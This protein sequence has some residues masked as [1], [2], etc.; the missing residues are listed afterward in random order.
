MLGGCALG[1]RHVKN[2]AIRLWSYFIGMR[3]YGTHHQVNGAVNKHG[4]FW[5]ICSQNE[6]NGMVVLNCGISSLRLR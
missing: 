1:F 4:T 3:L 2:L 6:L 5:A